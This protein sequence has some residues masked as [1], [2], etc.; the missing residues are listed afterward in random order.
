[1]YI[2][3]GKLKELGVTIEEERMCLSDY[4]KV[5]YKDKFYFDF[6]DS[7]CCDCAEDLIWEREIQDIF[8][9]GVELGILLAKEG[10][11]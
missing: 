3:L 11:V 7:S 6:N 9:S 4:I 1:M 8:L 10:K 5:K 2:D